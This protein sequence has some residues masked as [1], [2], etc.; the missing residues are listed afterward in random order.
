MTQKQKIATKPGQKVMY[1]NS[2]WKII[3]MD[4]TAYYLENL[5]T[6]EREYYIHLRNKLLVADVVTRLEEA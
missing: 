2:L 4:A 6:N 3:D 1:K 5:E